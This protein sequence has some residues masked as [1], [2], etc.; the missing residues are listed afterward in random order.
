MLHSN[1]TDADRYSS[2]AIARLVKDVTLED[3]SAPPIPCVLESH[4]NDDASYNDETRPADLVQ[5]VAFDTTY[6]IVLGRLT[7]CTQ[8][9]LM[10]CDLV[11]MTVQD[12]NQWAMALPHVTSLR[13][14]DSEVDTTPGFMLFLS[15]FPKLEILEL[16][17]MRCYDD[18][19]AS[20]YS[21]GSVTV[22]NPSALKHIH[23]DMEFPDIASGWLRFLVAQGVSPD[24]T[25]S[26][27]SYCVRVLPAMFFH[28]GTSLKH[29]RIH[30]WGQVS[31]D[32]LSL[33]GMLSYRL[34]YLY[35]HFPC[36]YR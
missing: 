5:P 32:E 19:L 2:P 13:M 24:F 20:G 16:R 25:L 26:L 33:F 21:P 22:A 8:L 18:P 30:S 27:H 34:E 15:A 23:I 6:R 29:L 17:D 4:A 36:I 10:A 35:P 31:H 7:Q 3:I 1:E 14:A 28:V 11:R 9:T 12:R